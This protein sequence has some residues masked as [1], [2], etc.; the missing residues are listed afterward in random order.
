MHAGHETH[1]MF[2]EGIRGRRNAGKP[3]RLARHGRRTRQRVLQNPIARGTVGVASCLHYNQIGPCYPPP[4]SPCLPRHASSDSVSPLSA[5]APVNASSRTGRTGNPEPSPATMLYIS[6]H[7][8][9]LCMS[10]CQRHGAI[11]T[12]RPKNGPW[13]GDAGPWA[14]PERKGGPPGGV[15]SIQSFGKETHKRRDNETQ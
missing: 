7:L 6:S 15:V 12:T 11:T 13:C 14:T 8:L 9:D 1:V 4:P 2:A 5:H 3:L 10:F